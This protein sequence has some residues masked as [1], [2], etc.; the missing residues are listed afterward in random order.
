MKELSK[1]NT[2]EDAWIC[3]E[4]KAYNVTK[5]ITC[6]AGGQCFRFC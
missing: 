1:H 3:I 4:G 6:H 5:Y 2:K